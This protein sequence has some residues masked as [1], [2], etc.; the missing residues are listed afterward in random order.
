MK[1]VSGC[2]DLL[3]PFFPLLLDLKDLFTGKAER[4]ARVCALLPVIVLGKSI[5]ESK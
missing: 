4:L 5:G 3:L 2:D 1:T